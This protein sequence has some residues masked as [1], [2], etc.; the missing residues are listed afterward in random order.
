MAPAAES[1]G[2][3]GDAVLQLRVPAPGRTGFSSMAPTTTGVWFTN[4]LSEA[5]AV[6][7]RI[8]EDGSGIALGDVDGDGRCDIY[9]CGLDRANALYRNL[10][11]WRFEDISDRAGIACPGQYS[12]GAALA[13]IDGDG[14]LDLLVNGLGVGTR[15][16]RND[17]QGHFTESTNTGLI[18]KYGSTSLA[19]A[20]IDGDGDLD[21]YVANYRTDT[22]RDAPPGVK[23]ELFRDAQGKV[24]VE[25][26]DRFLIVP[27]GREGVNLVERG[28]ADF[29]YLNDGKGEFT[30]V[31]W[32]SGRFRDE[33]GQP[34][35]RAPLYW[36]LTVAF[37]DLN[38]DGAP[39]IYVC[40]DFNFSPDQIWINDQRGHFQALPRLAM[41]E[42]TWSAMC[43]DFADINADG[44]LDFFVVEMLSRQH[45][46]RQTQ[47]LNFRPAA[48]MLPFGVFDNRPEYMRNTLFLNRGDG[49]YAEIA[50]FSGLEASEWTWTAA[51]LDVDLDGLDDLL[52]G[53]G[54]GHDVLDGDTARR[55]QE[56]D[57]SGRANRQTKVLSM[58]APL[59]TA[60]LA[61]HNRGDLTFADVSQTWGFDL[62]GISSA[63][64]LADLDNDGD[65]D[66]V[67]NNLNGL[68][69][70]YRNETAAPRVAVRL[71]GKAPNTHAIGAK[72]QLL[73]GPRLQTKEVTCGGRYLSSDDALRVFAA[74]PGNSD[75]TL[76]VA[77]PDGQT[78]LF[79]HVKP[80]Q[81]YVINHAV[82]PTNAPSAASVLEPSPP[83]LFEDVSQL[84]N[85]SHHEEAF[86]DFAR[87]PLLP[88]KLSQLGP[89]VTWFDS[90]G[91]GRE[92][93]VIG[94]G[95]GERLALFRNRGAD[96]FARVTPGPDEVAARDQTT[97][98][99]FAAAGQSPRLLV[100]SANYED[101]VAAGPCVRQVD[102]VSTRTARAFPGQVASTGP[103]AMADLDGDGDLDL[104]VGGRVVPGR[105]PQPASSLLFRNDQGQ[106]I[107]DP[108]NSSALAHV[109]LVS[110][111]VFT[112]LDS[113]GQPDLVLACEW[114]AVRLFHNERGRLADI[115]EQAGLGSLTGWWNGVTTGDF[116][117]DGQLDIIASNWGRNTK[118]ERHRPA[119][120]RIVY[121]DYNANG[122]IH[123]L[124]AYVDPQHQWLVPWR[125]LEVMSA[126]MPFLQSRYSTFQ[127]FA[128]ASL[129]EIL[130]SPI[131]PSRDLRATHLDTTVFLNRGGRFEAISLPNE[132]QFA[133]AFGVVAMDFDGDGHE[134]VFLSQNF[135]PVEMETS[136]YDAG[137]GLL[138]RGD[139]KGRFEP[140]SGRA[141]GI[142]LYGD[143]RGCAAADYDGD[144]RVDLA[145]AQNASVTK[146]FHN[147]QAKPGLR[148]RLRGTPANPHGVGATVRMISGEEIGPAR[149]V[150]AGSGYWSQDSSTLV[151]SAPRS[152]TGVLVRWPG[153]ATT[154]S[155]LAPGAREIEIEESAAV[156]VTP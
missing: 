43:V 109:G 147:V 99:A 136:R 19:L 125:T 16:F 107:L 113:D 81:L 121:G 6:E 74:G 76:S 150:H 105:Y 48:M 100:G 151:L 148:I 61:F 134:D 47:R 69:S 20:D 89:G 73:G 12:T 50:Q 93:L 53:N 3:P 29:L 25:P 2:R 72:I 129:G 59:R 140:M 40:N 31:S 42:M 5:H 32:T 90:D 64:A 126:A 141:S 92:D 96:G 127:A 35:R 30:P 122:V 130:G 75:L 21:L 97:I 144:G 68:V 44:H 116:D 38:D 77:W 78:R 8:R 4:A 27:Q 101:G 137:R 138:L 63:M 41:R 58:F 102:L 108:D 54:S 145:V 146:L 80:D 85:H 37:R 115:T 34:L 124:E 110:G 65:L 82:G 120:L 7:N 111:A 1:N 128:A 112:D 52:I 117:E 87:Q 153:G 135:F 70:L 67:V 155:A 11:D 23:A 154:R 45:Q 18:R 98:L 119:G 132:A 22:I 149:E 26:A 133:P 57:R 36:G 139:G 13:D 56:L 91:D 55:L 60:N 118:Y 106:F 79:P 51:F 46:L 86:D 24:I 28:E 123:P 15:L 103:L 39:D 9:L 142:L 114:G 66:V 14:D 33:D 17:G 62:V 143:Q 104:F 10:G 49:T 88:K 84:L 156:R 131:E 94:S 95:K 83:P 152:A 71:V